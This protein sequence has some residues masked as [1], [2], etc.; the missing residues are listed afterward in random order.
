MLHGPNESGRANET[1]D[2]MQQVKSQQ[3]EAVRLNDSAG[4]V[5]NPRQPQF[6]SLQIEI[7]EISESQDEPH[8]EK[9]TR[10]GRQDSSRMD[11]NEDAQTS[12]SLQCGEE[13]LLPSTE[14]KNAHSKISAQRIP[15]SGGAG[16][17]MKTSTHLISNMKQNKN[18][19]LGKMPCNSTRNNSRYSQQIL[20]DE[21]QPLFQKDKSLGR[22]R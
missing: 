2:G 5:N 20:D 11:K 17:L 9:S 14:K 1:G 15:K 19:F 8:K 12:H 7:P 6:K 22:Q 18:I 3:V 21:F 16:G 4:S 13:N 10:R